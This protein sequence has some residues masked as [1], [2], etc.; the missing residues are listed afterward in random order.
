MCARVQ[1]MY[2][3]TNNYVHEIIFLLKSVIMEGNIQIETNIDN[4]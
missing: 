4:A 2:S 1:C 3:I